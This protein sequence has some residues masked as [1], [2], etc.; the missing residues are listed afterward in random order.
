MRN[1]LTRAALAFCAMLFFAVMAATG[2]LAG[3]DGTRGRNLAW[4]VET[5]FVGSL[6]RPGAVLVFVAL[7][8]GFALAAW[9]WGAEAR[10]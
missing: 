9:R 10:R 7:G 5:V 3:I 4:L 1:P 8:A 2:A 6:G